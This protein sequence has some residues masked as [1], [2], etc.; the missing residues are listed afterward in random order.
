[1]FYNLSFIS[2]NSALHGLIPRSNKFTSKFLQNRVCPLSVS[3]FIINGKTTS[4][5]GLSSL[6]VLLIFSFDDC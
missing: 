2:G 3:K 5:S 1:M 4:S 6:R